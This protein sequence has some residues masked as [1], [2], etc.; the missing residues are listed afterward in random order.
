MIDHDGVDRG[1]G[2]VVGRHRFAPAPGAVPVFETVMERVGR[3]SL[4]EFPQPAHHG[5]LVFRMDQTFDW[6]ADR[7]SG[8]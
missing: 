6:M 8:V 5:A 4:Y 1:I 2:E 7:S 3:R